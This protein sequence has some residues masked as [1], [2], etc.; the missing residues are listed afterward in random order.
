MAAIQVDPEVLKGL[1]GKVVIITGAAN[2]IGKTAAR[3][4][5]GWLFQYPSATQD[6]STS[7]LIPS[8]EYGAS[9][10]IAD[11]DV[12]GG[13]FLAAEF[14]RL[15]F[16]LSPFRGHFVRADIGSWASQEALFSSTFEKFGSVDCVVANAA[17]PEKSDFLWEDEHD[18]NGRLKEPNL[19]LIDVNI[20][21]TLFSQ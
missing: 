4:F 18:E 11:L 7:F 6:T 21:G 9:V 3:L 10:T 17:M 14:G 2:G 19:T 5:Y 20:K 12:Q 16:T 8:T 15:V 13:K 1:A